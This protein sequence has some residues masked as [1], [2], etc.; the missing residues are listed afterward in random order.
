MGKINIFHGN[1]KNVWDMGKML[2]LFRIVGLMYDLFG[3]WEK[4]RT[5]LEYGK[6]MY[7]IFGT[8]EKCK[9]LLGIWEEKCMTCF[10]NMGK[11]FILVWDME[12]MLYLFGTWEKNVYQYQIYA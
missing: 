3:T 1:R 10:W 9:Y 11:L 4:C 12:K 7:D 8:W 5:S 6:N 2:Y